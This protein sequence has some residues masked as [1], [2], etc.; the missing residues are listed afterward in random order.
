MN[1][2]C[3]LIFESYINSNQQINN[4]INTLLLL[5]KENS[6]VVKAANE[7]IFKVIAYILNNLNSTYK[8]YTIN[9][10]N[11]RKLLPTSFWDFVMDNNLLSSSPTTTNEI[12]IKTGI[13]KL[14]ALF[15][16]YKNDKERE[17]LA[18]TAEVD[19][20]VLLGNQEDDD[21]DDKLVSINQMAKDIIE[22]IL[23]NPDR[24]KEVV[25]LIRHIPKPDR[26][27]VIVAMVDLPGGLK[28]H[29]II[30]AYLGDILR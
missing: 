1:R 16:K 14:K 28:A 21:S 7:D 29:K 13:D 11:Q 26:K 9:N 30:R 5:L 25:T 23:N 19:T 4:Y 18:N 12:I 22:I 15:G 6:E 17:T 2:D 10:I 3:Q 20:N 24:I 8:Q 27:D